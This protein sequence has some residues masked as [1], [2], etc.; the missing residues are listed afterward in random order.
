MPDVWRGEYRQ[1]RA[2]E[3]ASPYEVS[4]AAM[5]AHLQIR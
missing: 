5:A 2:V 3:G 1:K 4:G